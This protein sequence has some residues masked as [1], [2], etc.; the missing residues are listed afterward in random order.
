MA[1][2][3]KIILIHGMSATSQ[4]HWFPWLK[5]ELKKRKIKVTNRT[6]PNNLRAEERVLLDFLDKNLKADAN[7]ILIGHSS[8]AAVAMRYAESHKLYGSILIG[9]LYTDLGYKEEQETGLFKRKWNWEK[10]RKNQ[11]WIIQFASLDDPFIPIEQPR[12]IHKML[13]TEYHEYKDQK[14]FGSEHY[15]P[16]KFP[17]LLEK[18]FEKL[19]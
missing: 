1:T 13:K 15:S 9:A 17:D 2:I 3:P 19:K 5:K 8:G 4:N 18:T 11:N 16:K 10:I 7:T 14:H 12:Y 6:F